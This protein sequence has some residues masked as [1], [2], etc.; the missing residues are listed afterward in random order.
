LSQLVI[1][2]AA[3]FALRYR[4]QKTARAA[5]SARCSTQDK[6]G[7]AAAWRRR[8]KEYATLAGGHRGM[9]Q[10]KSNVSAPSHRVG[11]RRTISPAQCGEKAGGNNS[12]HCRSAQEF[13]GNSW[14]SEIE[15]VTRR[16][17]RAV[18]RRRAR[19]RCRKP[20]GTRRDRTD[21]NRACISSCARTESSGP[22]RRARTWG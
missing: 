13:G 3:A 15:G 12:V 14:P 17:G 1:A 7:L 9:E 8:S 21:P 11:D 6:N 18:V 2:V 22:T 20:H 4:S 16:D 10:W 5:R 19:R